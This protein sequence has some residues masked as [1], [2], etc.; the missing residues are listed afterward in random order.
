MSACLSGDGETPP[1][2]RREV[3]RGDTRSHQRQT[4]AAEPRTDA[5]LAAHLKAVQEYRV[6][7]SQEELNAPGVWTDKNGDGKKRLD[8]R[9]AVLR[10]SH[11]D[12]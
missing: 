6:T 11:P 9:I 12:G 5:H 1:G 8:A 2:G 3:P 10:A 7:F 4:Q